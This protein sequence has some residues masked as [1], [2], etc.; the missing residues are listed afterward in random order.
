MVRSTAASWIETHLQGNIKTSL[1]VCVCV[2]VCVWYGGGGGGGV[3]VCV[4]KLTLV[5]FIFL[6]LLG[7]YKRKEPVWVEVYQKNVKK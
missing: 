6:A 2:C 4:Q 3:C 5:K 1:C 7:F